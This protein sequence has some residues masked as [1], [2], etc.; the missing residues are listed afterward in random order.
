M[1]ERSQLVRGTNFSCTVPLYTD[2]VQTGIIT[3][4]ISNPS[5]PLN[6]KE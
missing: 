6:T 1:L 4:E 5:P 2:Q 3:K